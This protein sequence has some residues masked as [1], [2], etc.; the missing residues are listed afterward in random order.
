MVHS[1]PTVYRL[2]E[3]DPYGKTP[4]GLEGKVRFLLVGDM[5]FH[6]YDN[7]QCITWLS[8]FID[9]IKPEEIVFLGDVAEMLYLRRYFQRYNPDFSIKT[10]NKKEIEEI[11]VVAGN[12]CLKDLVDAEIKKVQEKINK[13]KCSIRRNNINATITGGNHDHRLNEAGLYFDQPSWTV[14]AFG[15][16]QA[17]INYVPYKK[18]H[19]SGGFQFSHH[20][21]ESCD[22][23]SVYGHLH[24]LNIQSNGVCPGV[25]SEWDPPH[26][27]HND[28]LWR[29][30]VLIDTNG[31]YH[32]IDMYTLRLRCGNSR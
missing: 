15:F 4:N 22:N 19:I 32:T 20:K 28:N 21:T 29:G 8:R 7:S 9:E 24:E 12:S 6:P 25:F 27:Q 26:W 10:K 13:L 2:F 23:I 31:A 16:N 14:D 17:G 5:H 18:I 1:K 11:E 3:A 30:L